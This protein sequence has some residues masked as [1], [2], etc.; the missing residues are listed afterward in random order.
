MFEI[1]RER[2]NGVMA[3]HITSEMNDRDTERLVRTIHMRALHQGKL[4]LLLLMDHY[5]SFNS[6]EAL[7]EDL[8]FVRQCEDKIKCMAIVSDQSWK[9][10]WVALFSLFSG[11]DAS[12]FDRTELE[13]AFQWVLN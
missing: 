4:G 12:Y 11:V 2:D 9:E 10:T 6:A 1:F 7:Y 3:L 5:A 8:R 13:E